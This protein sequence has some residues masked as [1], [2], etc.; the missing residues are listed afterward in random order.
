[1]IEICKTLKDSE[2]AYCMEAIEAVTNS[3]PEI[4]NIEYLKLASSYIDSKSNSLKRESARVIGNIAMLYPNDLDKP[5]KS[6]LNNAND[7]GTVVRWSA[8][9][10]L[11]RIIILPEYANSKLYNQ[12]VEICEKEEKNSIKN[13]YLKAFKKLKK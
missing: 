7:N 13:I 3:N 6:L 8:A 10:A 2:I 1:I 9:Y 4:S 5:I 11:S 12:L